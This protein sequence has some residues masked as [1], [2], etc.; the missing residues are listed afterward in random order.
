MPDEVLT[1]LC[2]VCHAEPHKYKCPGCGARTCSLPCIKKHKTRTECSGRH[3]PADYVPIEKLRTPA[4]IDHDYNFISAID[5]A[6][7]RAERDIVEELKLFR[8]DEL[9]PKDED[10]AFHKVWKGD[11]LHHV[12]GKRHLTTMNSFDKHIRKKLVEQDIEAKGMPKGMVRQKENATT[13]N[14]RNGC[15]N[16][17]IEWFVY[18][19][20]VLGD[21]QSQ[22]QQ[23]PTRILYKGL[24]IRPLYQLL[25][26]SIDWRHGQL[27]YKARHQQEESATVQADGE[28][29]EQD[30]HHNHSN[31][32][33]GAAKRK[34][35]YELSLENNQDHTTGTWPA[36][37][38]VMQYSLKGQWNQ[39]SIYC[40]AS[41]PLTEAERAERYIGWHFY[42]HQTGKPVPGGKKALIP[43]ESEETLAKALRGRSVVEF[44]TIYAF[45]P[46]M[47]GL[48]EGFVEG[49][50]ERRTRKR[51]IG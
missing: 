18:G 25:S 19:A 39:R 1:N 46:G 30:K 3:N 47:K 34:R 51:K 14:R 42:L 23:G 32:R 7:Q 38:L 17:Q 35:L 16:W 44:P 4:G 26:R 27:D 45:P 48:P 9:H 28:D 10:K 5:R 6:K 20:E 40:A 8:E 24:E 12:V 36:N 31:C 22:E 33:P 11:Q 37:S 43:L 49:S 2:S 21:R 50:T 15:I 13:F 29:Q 41:I